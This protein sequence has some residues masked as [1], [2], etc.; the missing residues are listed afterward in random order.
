MCHVLFFKH[1]S[2]IYSS[3]APSCPHPCLDEANSVTL[4]LG[5]GTN[6]VRKQPQR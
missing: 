5:P 3:V 1:Y 6:K 2:K 4:P